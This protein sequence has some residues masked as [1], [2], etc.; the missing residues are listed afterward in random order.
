MYVFLVRCGIGYRNG[1]YAYSKGLNERN[2][3]TFASEQNDSPGP[4]LNYSYA[5]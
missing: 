1:E 3:L 2:S 4:I 5:T